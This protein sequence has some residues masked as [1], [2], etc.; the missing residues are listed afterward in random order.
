MVNYGEGKGFISLGAPKCLA[1][2]LLC[3]M[4]KMH[5]FFQ[6]RMWIVL[7]W[8]LLSLLT[9]ITNSFESE[10]KTIDVCDNSIRVFTILNETTKY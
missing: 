7:Y 10:S 1:Y 8:Y 5:T 6:I 2:T 4:R 9:V 3:M